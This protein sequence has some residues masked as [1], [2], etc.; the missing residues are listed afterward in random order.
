MKTILISTLALFTLSLFILLQPTDAVDTTEWS[1][2]EGAKSR[3]GKGHISDIKYSPDEKYLAVAGSVGVWIYDA[4]TGEELNL[5]TG[6]DIGAVNSISF[7]SDGQLLAIGSHNGNI[8]IWDVNI[9]RY[10]HV[11]GHGGLRSISFSPDGQTLASGGGQ[12]LFLWNAQT[13]ERIYPGFVGHTGW[14]NSVAFSPDG[15]TLASAAEDNTIRLWSVQT[16]EL[17]HTITEHTDKIHSVAFSPDGQTLASASEDNT[18]RLWNAQTTEHIQTFEHWSTQSVAFS[19]DGKI[20]ASGGFGNVTLWDVETVNELHYLSGYNGQ[21]RSVAFSRDGKMLAGGSDFGSL[22]LRDVNTGELIP[23]ITGHTGAVRS[24]AF[25]PNGQIF[26]NTDYPNNLRLWNAQTGELLHTL[27]GSDIAF[28]RESQMLAIL[29]NEAIDL[30]DVKTGERL[31]TITKNGIN[32]DVALSPNGEMLATGS[33]DKNVPIW[34]VKTR[35]LR[36]TLTGHRRDVRSVAFSPDSRT[37]ASC[38][39]DVRLW[40]TE[41]G[42]L[43]YTLTGHRGTLLFDVSFSPDGK[44]LAVAGLGAVSLWDVKTGEILRTL[45]ERSAHSVAFS[46]DGKTL[47]CDQDNTVHLWDTETGELLQEL[48][49]HTDSIYSV[50]F[51]PDGRTLAS[52]SADGTVLLWELAPSASETDSPTETHDISDTVNIAEYTTTGHLPEGAK[53]RIGKGTIL[54]MQYTP[55]GKYLKVISNIGFWLY[56]AE[57]YQELGMRALSKPIIGGAVRNDMT[58]HIVI[59]PDGATGA[60]ET[61]DGLFHLWDIETGA[62]LHTISNPTTGVDVDNILSFSPDGKTLLTRSTATVYLW[63]VKTGSLLHTF[64]EAYNSSFYSK[65]YSFSP[66]GAILALNIY[67]D[68]RLW[69]IKT[70]T[71]LH[72]LVAS[73]PNNVSCIAFSPDGK[74]LVGGLHDGYLGQIRLWDVKTGTLLQSLTGPATLT[75][76]RSSG[77][78]GFISIA[79]SPDGKTFASGGIDGRIHLWSAGTRQLLGTITEITN[80]VSS[81]PSQDLTYFGDPTRKILFSPDGKTLVGR[82]ESGTLRVWDV[83]T[84]KHLHTFGYMPSVIESIAFSSDGKTFATGSGF[85]NGTVGLW[86]VETGAL[87]HSFKGDETTVNSVVFSPDGKT[88]A[89]GGRD[90]TLRLWDVETGNHLRSIPGHTSPDKVTSIHNISFSPDGKTIVIVR[91]RS[92][93][94]WDAETGNGCVIGN[95]IFISGSPDILISHKDEADVAVA[96]T[97]D[98]KTVGIGYATYWGT[99]RFIDVE[100][101]TLLRVFSAESYGHKFES[102]AFSPDGKTLIG[103]SGGYPYL[104]DVDAEGFGPRRILQDQILEVIR[105]SQIEYG[106]RFNFASALSPGGKTLAT[107]VHT[108]APESAEGS[109][110]LWDV[111]TGKRLKIFDDVPARSVV[112]SADGKTLASEGGSGTVLLWEVTPTSSEPEK[113]KEDINAD[114]AVN[115]QDLVA[116]AAALGQTGENDADVNGD[117]EV[118]IQDLVAVAA[119]LGEVAAAPSAIRQQATGHLTA[120]D[121]QQW[122]RQVQQLDLTALKTQRGLLFLQYLLAALTPQETILLANYPNPFNPETWI[123]Y[124]LAKPTEVTLTIYAVDGKLVRTLDLGHQPVGIYESKSR[125]AYWDGKNEIGESVASGVYFYTLTAGDFTAT[126]K[127]LIRK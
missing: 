30:W 67:G 127:M 28:S 18:V 70:G 105:Q 38:G 12:N 23:R 92:V 40:N 53:T 26:A 36:H 22:I 79:F 73:D 93:G 1:L 87:L 102:L 89:T 113:I 32:N 91:E 60:R 20:L 88:L 86:N 4:Q 125:A 117:G 37:L 100:G 124:Q 84:R 52:G 5:H 74:T 97:P 55:D 72:T 15:Q 41:T 69:D 10:R 8:H 112:F 27:T 16:K 81:D 118:N 64:T 21:V 11:I 107:G 116:V 50:A 34:D 95:P 109:I 29:Q 120:A 17:L 46:P 43:R 59:S 114:G 90:N 51:S 44:T 66:D 33:W 45:I 24:V 65:N 9:G 58:R 126:R 108:L 71:L 54:D 56:D 48:S 94:L 119:A 99:L 14:I 68:I 42:D 96:F 2:P 6:E 110:Y 25:S 122:I 85:A 106:T 39:S 75:G 47:A 57:T 82:M 31:H 104:W 121:V 13:G 115:I 103:V 61:D 63:D 77:A 98:G 123:P 76:S 80:L 83:T 111:K 49:G 3:I 19:P 78:R 35:T 101:C 62:L 7:N